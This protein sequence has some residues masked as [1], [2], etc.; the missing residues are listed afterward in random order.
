MHLRQTQEQRLG[1]TISSIHQAACAN[2]PNVLRLNIR[3]ADHGR[4]T[5]TLAT[6]VNDVR[7]VTNDC[8]MRET[9]A[10]IASVSNQDFYITRTYGLFHRPARRDGR[11]A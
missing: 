6:L 9:Q 1:T 3:D 7:S 4:K 11:E 2:S 8:W 10:S 5:E